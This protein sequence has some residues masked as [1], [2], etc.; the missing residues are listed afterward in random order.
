M[1]TTQKA[2]LAEQESLL[3][4]QLCGEDGRPARIGAVARRRKRKSARR[5]SL[6]LAT[7]LSSRRRIRIHLQ[8]ILAAH[9][10]RAFGAS[11]V[12]CSFPLIRHTPRI[13]SSIASNAHLCFKLPDRPRPIRSQTSALLQSNTPDI[14]FAY[15]IP[16]RQTRRRAL[17]PRPGLWRLQNGYARSPDGAFRARSRLSGVGSGQHSELRLEAHILDE[18]EARNIRIALRA[19]QGTAQWLEYPDSRASE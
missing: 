7:S 17:S 9:I 6:V 14:L 10:L 15:C 3:V 18:S 11:A 19:I 5:R 2:K 13:P 4:C 12:L 16:P 8:P 1:D